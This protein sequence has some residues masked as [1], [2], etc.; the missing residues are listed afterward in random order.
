[1]TTSRRSPLARLLDLFSSITLGIWLIGL[2]FVYCSVGSAGIVYPTSSGIFSGDAW[3]HAQIRQWRFFEMTEFEWFHWWPFKALI[4]LIC[5][6][7]TVATLRR[8]PLKTLNLG[9]WM[10][11][12]GIVVLCLGSWVYFDLKVEGDVPVVRREV[13]VV[14]P[15]GLAGRFYA[16]PGN[17]LRLDDVQLRV[18][19]VDPEYR[20]EGAAPGTGGAFAVKVQVQLGDGAQFVRT[21]VDGHPELTEELVASGDP[22]RPMQLASELSGRAVLHEDVAL[23]LETVP[24]THFYLAH[25]VQKSWALYVREITGGL[26]GPWVERP[27]DGLPLYNDSVRS[28]SEIWTADGDSAPVHPL[29]V[30]VPAVHADD[31][32]PG[33]ELR[34]TDYLRYAR[35]EQRRAPGGKLDPFAEVLLED[36]VGGEWP[37][38]LEAF[39]PIKSRV[40]DDFLAFFWVDD[41]SELGGFGRPRPPRLVLTPP[42][43]ESHEHVVTGVVL[44]DPEAEWNPIPGSELEFR[45]EFVQ[46]FQDDALDASMA[47]VELRSP[48][49]T[50]RRWVFDAANAMRNLDLETSAVGPDGERQ[51]VPDPGQE[52]KGLSELLGIRYLPGVQPAPV[53]LLAGP[54]PDQLG[55]VLNYDPAQ[56]GN[57]LPIVTGERVSLG[58]GNTLTVT[59]YASHSALE[60]RPYRVP[61]TA[62]NSQ[63]RHRNAMVAVEV[64]GSREGRVWVPFQ[65]YPVESVRH[66][67]RRF[68]YDPSEV[69]MADGRS[70]QLVLSR[71]RFALPTPVVLEDFVLTEHVGGY[72]GNTLSVRDWTSLVRFSEPDGSLTDAMG[73]SVNSPTEHAGL[74]YFQMEWDPP[75][76]RPV[77]GVTSKGLNFT[78]LGVGNRHGVMLQLLGCVVAVLGMIYAFYVKPV[79][80][81]RIVQRAGASAGGVN[82]S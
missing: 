78:V 40:D 2:L 67:M 12:T 27:V 45:I 75:D 9:V 58:S 51:L 79:L 21:L 15:G 44:N 72:T 36:G 48:E 63:V 61:M 24:A 10:I 56:R 81:R 35:M 39:D 8:I 54:A 55:I 50:W 14:T 33:A 60:M 74:S 52:L 82:R 23:S 73:V 31:P 68:Q 43:G 1:M 30:T 17:A 11:H 80:R 5:V 69:H 59:D 16:V 46:D 25:W 22:A 6:N 65:R 70:Y 66:T 77:G 71:Q 19:S 53:T 42:G 47:S 62:R 29:S 3:T 26:A 32:L 13:A 49:K 7:L 34:I 76:D 28:A 4:V 37:Y 18:W 57:Y 20:P 64:P 38:T 41:E